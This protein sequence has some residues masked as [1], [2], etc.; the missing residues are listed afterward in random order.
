MEKKKNRKI[1]LIGRELQ[2]HN[3]LAKVKLPAVLEAE[4]LLEHTLLRI[5]RPKVLPTTI[6]TLLELSKYINKER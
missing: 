4:N 6:K 1:K 3:F 2:K 5:L